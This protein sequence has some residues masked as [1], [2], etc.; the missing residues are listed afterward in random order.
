MA[1]QRLTITLT[2]H[3]I[4]VECNENAFIT[5]AVEQEQKWDKESCT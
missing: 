3:I 4:A 1:F 2:L 5:L